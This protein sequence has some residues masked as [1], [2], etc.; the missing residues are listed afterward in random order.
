MNTKSMNRI[1]VKN[2]PAR[3]FDVLSRSL[4]VASRSVLQWRQNADSKRQIQ[5]LNAHLRKDAGLDQSV[6]TPTHND[7]SDP[8]SWRL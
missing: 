2:A 7:Y 8:A 3:L 6:S 1:G 5:N 4:S